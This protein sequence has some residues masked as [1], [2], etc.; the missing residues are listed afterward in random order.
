MDLQ[1]NKVKKSSFYSRYKETTNSP[2]VDQRVEGG[3]KIV[4]FPL[5]FNYSTPVTASQQFFHRL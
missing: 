4:L 2:T 1:R 3:V 5:L